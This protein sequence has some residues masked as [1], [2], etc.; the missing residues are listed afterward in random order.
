MKLYIIRQI[1]WNP[2]NHEQYAAHEHH[3]AFGIKHDIGANYDLRRIRSALADTE[4]QGH[5]IL[6]S[7]LAKYLRHELSEQMARKIAPDI[8]YQIDRYEVSNGIVSS[9]RDHTPQGLTIFPLIPAD[10]TT[11]NQERNN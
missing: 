11:T 9:H 5:A 2:P 10:E 1:I 4:E 7:I 3:A 6:R 8:G